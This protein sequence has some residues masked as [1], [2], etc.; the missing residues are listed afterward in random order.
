MTDFFADNFRF[1]SL[2]QTHL[3]IA[4]TAWGI[5][6]PDIAEKLKHKQ[7]NVLTAD[8]HDL[9]ANTA[10]KYGGDLV[11]FLTPGNRKLYIQPDYEKELWRKAGVKSSEE[12]KL[13]LIGEVFILLDQIWQQMSEPYQLELPK[14]KNLFFMRTD[15]LRGIVDDLSTVCINGKN[16]KTGGEKRSTRQTRCKAIIQSPEYNIRPSNAQTHLADTIQK[17]K[18]VY[19]E[20]Y[21]ESLQKPN[22][23]GG[24]TPCDKTITNW[25]YEFSINHLPGKR[26]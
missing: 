8:I 11:G 12:N 21:G 23:K 9:M 26:A 6:R 22:K 15:T 24:I 20:I 10:K 16:A 17:I 19:F 4:L 2:F 25:I 3:S 18:D 13:F 7:Y 1:K 14:D 5:I